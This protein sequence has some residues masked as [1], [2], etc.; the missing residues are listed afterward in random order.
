MEGVLKE[1]VLNKKLYRETEILIWKIQ[2]RLHNLKKT[3][4]TVNFD[5]NGI[6][7]SSIAGYEFV[8]SPIA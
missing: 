2:L 3:K 6:G 8:S 7:H 4:V 1:E 5:E